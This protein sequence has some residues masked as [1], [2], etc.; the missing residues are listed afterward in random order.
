MGYA[1]EE[2]GAD[3]CRRIAET[4]FKVEK[5][6]GNKLHGFCP[7]HGDKTS[8]SFVYHT[9]ED[10]YKCQSCGVGGDLINLWSEIHNLDSRG[11]GFKAF[12]A[13]FIGGA[14]GD[15]SRPP[16]KDRKPVPQAATPDVFIDES[17]LGALPP[18]PLA[19]IRE[20]SASR[21]WSTEII[22]RLQLRDF[23][24]SRSKKIAI[25]IR[26]DEGRLCNIRLYQ[27]GAE[28]FKVI[29]WYDRHCQSCGA[30]WKKAKKAKVCS[31]C[32]GSPND[33][34]RTRLYPPPSQWKPS[35]QLWLVEGEPDLICALSQGLNAVTQTAG[36]GT[37]RDE[38]SEAM[39][40]R[41]VVIAYDADKP[42]LLGSELVAQS[43]VR[44]A[45]SVRIHLWKTPVMIGEGPKVKPNAKYTDFVL[46]HGGDYPADHGMD[47]TD[48][49]VVHG[50]TMA[51]LVDLLPG[52]I[53][54]E[55]PKDPDQ[56]PAVLRFF[57]GRKFAPALLAK[58]I[59]EDVDISSDPL[60]GLV[61][62]WEGRYWEQYDL[63]YLRSKALLMLGDEGNSARAAD[64]ANMVRDLSVLPIGR[65]M[66][67]GED[68][69]CLQNGMFNLGKGL[70]AGKL[71]QHRK[72]FYATHCL[73]VSF[74]PL[75]VKD[76]PRWQHFLDETVQDPEVIKELQKFF[77][78]CLTRETRY[79]KMLLLHGP[80]GDGK[81]TL[82]NVLR[83]LVGVENCSH[84]PMGRLDD[85][86]YL[87][88]LVD[89]LLNMSTEVESKAMQ[90]QEI[91]AIVSGDPISASFKNQTPF[92]FVP[93]CKLVYSTNRLPRMLDNSDGFFR[94]I[95]IIE[96][97]GQFVKKGRADLFLYE[98]LMQE[99][100]GIFA[101]ALHGLVDLREEGF[102]A[103]ATM[104]ASLHDYKRTNNNVLYFI[105]QR[106]VADP[107][108]K[109]A[110][111]RTFEEYA[112]SCKGWGLMSVGEPYFRKEFM[113]LLGDF[114]IPVRD[115]KVADESSQSGRKNAYVGFRLVDEKL[116]AD[117]PAPAP[118]PAELGT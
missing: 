37:W 48:W 64:V 114:E 96:M 94:K 110:K 74:D 8:A 111:D 98:E 75:D 57:K 68:L 35:G 95:M 117:S 116:E 73:G 118:H 67:D 26:D 99:L 87:S 107:E 69:I 89:K 21:G 55:P 65:R 1:L 90:S 52:A 45:R 13:E 38:F 14:P 56:D 33:Y 24:P 2:L 77:G 18:L 104:E 105:E 39:A 71:M 30:A 91:K 58:V 81:S 15:G 36:C 31:G 72:D 34:G 100:P 92:D 93:A 62:R 53:T 113:R 5:V 108:G 40:G 25:P 29:S 32:G 84:I 12:K 54:I 17:E 42:G 80:G 51:D 66:N 97:K 9:S 50:F 16:R 19:R 7:I 44:H 10:W 4:L 88:R 63:Q 59:M 61:Y 3:G 22:E 79:E 115:G 6:Y 109:T 102:T 83:Q 101:W 106:L 82:M 112:K 49:F 86:F 20:L 47:L 43:I 85:Q 76:C 46:K 70:D 23:N 27:P 60:T 11:D 78:Y 103:S 28:Q 41:D